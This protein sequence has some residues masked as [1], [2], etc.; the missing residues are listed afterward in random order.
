MDSPILTNKQWLRRANFFS[1]KPRTKVATQPI[2][3]C[4]LK[5]FCTLLVRNHP[6]EIYLKNL[7]TD[8]QCMFD[9]HVGKVRIFGTAQT[10]QS[11]TD[12]QELFID[13][14]IVHAQQHRAGTPKSG[15]NQTAGRSRG[16]LNT[17]THACIDALGNPTRLILTSS[18]SG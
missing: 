14:T 11:D 15:A 5:R 2:T 18:L 6:G 13:A 7:A 12:L 10:L 1:A 9:L 4:L 8:T 17:K 3:D 16:G